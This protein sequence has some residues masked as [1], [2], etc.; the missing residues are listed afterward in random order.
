M[1]TAHR[2]TVRVRY[3][4]TDPMGRL[5]HTVHLVYFEM[6]RTEH[7]R[8]HGFSYREMEAQRRFVVVAGLEIK[9]RAAA[10]YDDELIIET[11]VL[12]A[13]GAKVVFGNRLLRKD[14][15][16]EVVIAEATITAALLGADGQLMRF[17]D[18]DVKVLLS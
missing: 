13:R 10:R 11:R 12:D 15:V 7:L 17:S 16:G 6:G 18:E 3:P 2:M 5:H 4:E 14:P 8:T 1:P 9:Y